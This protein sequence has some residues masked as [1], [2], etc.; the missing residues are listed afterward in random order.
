MWVD[1]LRVVNTQEVH[2]GRMKIMHMEAVFH[3]IEPQVIGRPD[4]LPASHPA[5]SHPHGEARGVVVAS[6]VLLAHRRAPKLT[7]PDHEGF[8]EQST[9]LEVREQARDGF[10]DGPAEFRVA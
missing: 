6:A 9:R 8:V 7:T 3:G 5:P 2:D 1:Q 4:G 10:V